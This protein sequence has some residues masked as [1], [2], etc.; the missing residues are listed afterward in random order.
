MAVRVGR[1]AKVMY[2]GNLVAELANWTIEFCR[3]W[4]QS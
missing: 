2:D 3:S 4:E 1:K